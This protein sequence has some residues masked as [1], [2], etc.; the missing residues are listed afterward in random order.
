MEMVNLVHVP[1]KPETPFLTVSE[2]NM[3]LSTHIRNPR[4]KLCE[5]EMDTWGR[6][7]RVQPAVRMVAW[8]K[9]TCSLRS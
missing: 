7:T 9:L 4:K 1:V 3:F 5:P 2:R 6:M 8:G